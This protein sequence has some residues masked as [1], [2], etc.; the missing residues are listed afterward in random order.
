MP[1]ITGS[2]TRVK[3]F[4]SPPTARG[5]RHEG[6]RRA[7][8]RE[9]QHRVARRQRRPGGRTSPS[10][11]AGR[12]LLGYRHDATATALRRNDRLSASI[13]VIFDDVANPFLAAV[14]RGIEEVA[15]ERGV[16][17]FVGSSDEQGARERLLAEAFGARGVDGLI[18]APAPRSRSSC[19]TATPAWRSSS[20]IGPGVHRRRRVLTD[21]AGGA[22]A[23]AHLVAAVMSASASSATAPPP[24][25]GRGLRGSEAAL[26][27]H[28]LPADTGSCGHR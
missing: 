1:A 10:A 12:R 26:A 18:I 9:P 5:G 7:S 23:A 22:A 20:S 19:A 27:Q 25:G 3:R 24:H 2:E 15:R 8:R 17:T 4:P 28:G 21:N 13:G 16:L 11:C 14:L 6:G